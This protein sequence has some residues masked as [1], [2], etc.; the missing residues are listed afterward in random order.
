V[1]L[2]AVL[3]TAGSLFAVRPANAAGGS[4]GTLQVLETAANL[5]NW[6]GLDPATD[7]SDAA[8]H[9]Y[10]NAIYGELFEQ[11]PKGA[12]PDLAQGYKLSKDLKTLNIFLRH[13]VTFTDG[14][15]FNAKA[16][17]FNFKRDLDPANACLCLSSFPVASITTPNAYT[18]SLKLTKPFAP[19]VSAFFSEAPNW[20]VSPTALQKMGEKAFA[21]TPVGAGPF[22]VVSDTPSASLVLK[23]NPNYWQQGRPYLAGI[24]FTVVGNDQS[25]YNALQSGQGQAYEEF[26]TYSLLPSIA[27]SIKVTPIVPSPTGTIA[28]QFNTTV[29]P[30]NNIAAREAIYYATNPSPINKALYLGRAVP[31]QSL[32]SPGELFYQP[33]VSGYRTY[34]PA[35][36]KAL[37]AQL[38]GLSIRLDMESS[39]ASLAEA[40][41]SEWNQVGIKTS[42]HLET[43]EDNLGDYKS[44]NWQ[45]KFSDGGGYD[46]GILLGLSFYY[47]SNAPFTGYKD[48]KLDALIDKGVSVASNKARSAA[49]SQIYKYISDHAYSPVLFF[50]PVFNLTVP[51]VSGPGL[52]TEGPE[53]F[54]E[55]VKTS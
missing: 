55:D 54:W 51:G 3:V 4:G 37:V 39:E 1:A 22:E 31:T 13:G 6:P 40:L 36:A 8:D 12:I 27:K 20:I 44:N 29:A 52:T 48:P 25:A 30:F 46:P 21:L 53:I 49:Y 9:D 50:A 10:L 35:K 43:F 41:A 11:G 38:G 5:G 32:R 17:A 26:G 24:K 16:V 2:A 18:V 7:G 19:I 45:A 23:R 42:L 33:K 14:T 34:N 15:P 28:V 47:A